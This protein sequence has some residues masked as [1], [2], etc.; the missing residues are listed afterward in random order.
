MIDFIIIGILVGF[1]V[2]FLNY[3]LGKPSGDFSPYEVFSNYTVWL[4]KRR[5]EE[6]GLYKQYCK[7]YN[8]NLLRTNSKHE[9]L[10][11]KN[12]FKKMLYNAAD[13]FFTW[14]RAAGMCPVCFGFWISLISGLFF[15]NNIVNLLI[16]IVTSHV[17]IRVLNKIL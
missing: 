4:S 5:L 3:C 17:I 2:T 12:D 9:V 15:T 11:L 14:E 7:D 10:T 1:L 8:E 6:V 13:P 16:I